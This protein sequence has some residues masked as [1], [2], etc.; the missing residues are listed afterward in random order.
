M[1]GSGEAALG[2][3]KQLGLALKVDAA[4]LQGRERSLCI[5]AFSST[6]SSIFLLLLL[7]FSAEGGRSRNVLVCGLATADLHY[8]DRWVGE[9][10]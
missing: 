5:L 7:E 2:L 8:I 3:A 1:G 6:F 10:K 9:R 4:A